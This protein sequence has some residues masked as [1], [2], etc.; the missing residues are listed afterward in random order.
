MFQARVKSELQ[1]LKQKLDKVLAVLEPLVQ[2]HEAKKTIKGSDNVSGS[3]RE[4]K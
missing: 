4:E 1:E 3:K 2:E